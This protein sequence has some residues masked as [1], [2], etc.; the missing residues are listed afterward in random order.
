MV[1]VVAALVLLFTACTP[2]QQMA[3]DHINNNR[4]N[5]GVPNL[6]PHGDLIVKAQAWA[7]NLAARGVIEHSHLS[8]GAPAGWQMLAENVG[9]GPSQL[10]VMEQF[11]VSPAHRA[12]MLNPDFT[13]VGTGVAYGADGMVYVVEVFARY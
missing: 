1:A 11:L 5:A 10:A 9:R 13:H 6:L 4:A 2:E 12:N 8:D 7:E 3:H